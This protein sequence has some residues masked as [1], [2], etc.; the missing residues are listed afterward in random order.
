MLFELRGNKRSH[1]CGLVLEHP[2]VNI[3]ILSS[4]FCIVAT[5]YMSRIPNDD[6][7]FIV[8]FVQYYEYKFQLVKSSPNSLSNFIVS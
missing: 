2:A 7:V 3:S 8:S 4:F 1:D 5:Q 6:L